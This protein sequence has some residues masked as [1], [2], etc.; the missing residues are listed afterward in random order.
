M[1]RGRKAEASEILQEMLSKNPEKE[2][3]F[4]DVISI[5]LYGKMYKEA[6]LCFSR[7]ENNTGEPLEKVDWPLEEIEKEEKEYLRTRE[8]IKK[9][10][11][12]IFKKLTKKD[13]VLFGVQFNIFSNFSIKEIRIAEDKI[14]ICKSRNE[15]PYFW[16]QIN[17]VLIN[18]RHCIKGEEDYEERIMKILTKDRTFK[19]DISENHGIFLHSDLLVSEISKYFNVEQTERS[20]I[21]VPKWF[22]SVINW[23][24]ILGMFYI[25]FAIP[26]PF[27]VFGMLVVIMIVD[28][29]MNRYFDF[30]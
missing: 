13:R 8:E 22:R 4:S 15:Y 18:K 9:S 12:K 28:I 25:I 10:K 27:A 7:Y 3:V 20:L 14:V 1:K 19:F 30:I 21:K 24:W 26:T 16:N 29:I 5:Y 17:T 23:C 2:T 11:I 6:K